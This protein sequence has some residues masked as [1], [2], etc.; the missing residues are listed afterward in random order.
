MP[1]RP[2]LASHMAGFAAAAFFLMSE[3]HSI[4]CL[5]HNCIRLS[6][7]ADLCCFPVFAPVDNTGSGAGCRCLC[8]ITFLFLSDIF[9]EMGLLEH[10][11]VLFFIF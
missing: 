9:P 2:I 1:S 6:I 5:H 3:K 8:D 4:V 7:R 11:V 10:M